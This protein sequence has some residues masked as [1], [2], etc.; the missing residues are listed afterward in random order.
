MS[1][2]MLAEKEYDKST[3]VYSFGI[4]AYFVLTGEL[5]KIPLTKKALGCLPEVPPYVTKL[6][7]EIILSCCCF[8]PKDRP[9]FSDLLSL[10]EKN[11]FQLISNINNSFVRQ[12]YEEL[13][14]FKQSHP[15]QL[16]SK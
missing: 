16:I 13:M 3:D 10:M 12:R 11:N 9:S 7:K 5:P 15:A 2:E 8:N 6:G 1:P 14:Q 4:L